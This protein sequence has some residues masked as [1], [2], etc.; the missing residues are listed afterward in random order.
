[1]P[2]KPKTLSVELPNI[3]AELLESFGDDPMTTEAIHAASLT[4]KK[5]LIKRALNGELNH[6]VGYPVGAPSRS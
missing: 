4:F 5:A 6:H 2:R 1:M 3:L